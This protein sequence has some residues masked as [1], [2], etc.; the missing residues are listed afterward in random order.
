[1]LDLRPIEAEVPPGPRRDRAVAAT[2]RR[3]AAHGGGLVR[4][5][6]DFVPC[7]CITY[8][9][10]ASLLEATSSVH[11]MN[12]PEGVALP[13]GLPAVTDGHVHVFPDRVFEALWRWFE[14]H[15]WPIRYRL[16]GPEVTR[17]L[18]DRGVARAV[19]LHYGHKPGMSRAL[20]GFIAELAKEDPRI[21]PF[22]TVMPGEPDVGTILEEARALGLRGVKLHCHVQAFA[23]DSAEAH[24]VFAACERLGLPLLIH[25][26][27]EPKSEAYPVDTYAVCAAD[28]VERALQSFPRLN[29]CVPHF[30][31]DEYDAYGRMLDR[32]DNLWLDTTCVLS[33]LVTGDVPLHWFDKRPERIF[34]GTDFPN[35]PYAWDR[36][37]T[38]LLEL[39]LRDPALED[40]LGG[41]VERFLR[42]S[43]SAS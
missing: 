24:E 42:T 32:Y 22:A 10:S 29:L 35:L 14:T 15:A 18:F 28:R 31:A 21:V 3:H 23:A 25:A 38:R 37:V 27:R 17:Y 36:E 2:L 12:E 4:D 1:M 13:S 8:L 16:R 41:S 34:F 7:A 33:G 39:E 30:G 43:V 9:A 19:V 40:I 5:V 11:A 6:E 20:N 26:G